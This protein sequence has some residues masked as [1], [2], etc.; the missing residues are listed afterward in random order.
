VTTDANAEVPLALEL[1]VGPLADDG[2]GRVEP[3]ETEKVGG[4]DDGLRDL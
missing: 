1:A 2:V 4:R 3:S